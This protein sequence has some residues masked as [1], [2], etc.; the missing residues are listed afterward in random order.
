MFTDQSGDSIASLGEAELIRRIGLWLGSVSPSPPKG[1]GDD[2]AVLTS[3]NKGKQLLTT[4][5]LTY[6]QHF[7]DGM[8]PEDAGA[9]LIKRNL[10][11][12][13]AM[14]GVP[15]PALLNLLSGPNLSIDW[16]EAFIKGVRQT[17]AQYEV[18]LV[19]GDVSALQ[20]DQFSA[21]LMQTGKAEHPL[22]RSGAKLGDSIYVTGTLGGSILG[23]HYHFKPR[24]EEGRWLADSDV[25]TAMMDLTDGLA[26]DLA[27]I[28]P[29]NCAAWIN[30]ESIPL[31]DDIKQ[32]KGDPL[33]HAFCDGEDYELLFTLKKSA[34]ADFEKKWYDSFPETVL[35]KIGVL[36]E[37]NGNA[38]YIND[39]D[40][41]PLPWRKGFEHLTSI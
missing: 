16:L 14:G 26:K 3:E 35:T 29:E 36:R 37:K 2:C 40:G 22:L 31:S 10:S 1:M 23:K 41:T 33:E 24:L 15:G 7:D 25:C 38:S 39:A 5:S 18:S 12:I 20:A 21:I 13:A 27:G 9:K 32:L 28:V 6:Q 19:G 30:I 8:R 4:D 34:S 11:D 17:C